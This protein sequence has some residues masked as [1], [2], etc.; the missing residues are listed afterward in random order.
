[1]VVVSNRDG[2]SGSA[3]EFSDQPG[4]PITTPSGKGQLADEL[5]EAM[6]RLE[7]IQSLPLNDPRRDES[8]D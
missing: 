6:R 7:L 1:L 2:D 8:T 4:E 5:A 3:L